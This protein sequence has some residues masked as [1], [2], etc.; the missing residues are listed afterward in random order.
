[1]EVDQD[2]HKI[3]HDSEKA[4]SGSLKKGNENSYKL[5]RFINALKRENEEHHQT[6][7]LQEQ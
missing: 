7:A 2:G 5:H 3:S 4:G 6:M 1:M